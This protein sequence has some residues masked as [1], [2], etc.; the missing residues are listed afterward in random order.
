MYR[1]QPSSLLI[2]SADLHL[3]WKCFDSG[4]IFKQSEQKTW[5]FLKVIYARQE[6]SSDEISLFLPSHKQC[7]RD[8]RRRMGV[9]TT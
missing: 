2:V 4:E 1:N 3:L 9:F 5:S 6:V 8:E 7:D